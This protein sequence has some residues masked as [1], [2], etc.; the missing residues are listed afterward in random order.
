MLDSNIDK[1]KERSELLYK[2]KELNKE[3]RADYK[4]INQK[5]NDDF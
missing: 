1:S 2:E 5:I 3:I 4:K